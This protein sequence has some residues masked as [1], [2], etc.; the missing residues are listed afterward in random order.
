M[1]FHPPPP[2]PLKGSSYVD[3]TAIR[4]RHWLRAAKEGQGACGTRD[5][6]RQPGL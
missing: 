5:P 4:L 6:G 1:R 2:V 3:L